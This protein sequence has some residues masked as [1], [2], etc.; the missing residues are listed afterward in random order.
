[1]CI[2]AAKPAG[3]SMPDRETIR[4]MWNGNRDGAGLMYL[5]K[6][7]VRIEKGFMAYKDLANHLDELERRLDLKSIPVVMHLRITTHGGTKP[8]NTHPFPITDSV[9]AL[10]K[11]TI[12]TDVGVAHNGIIPITP[13]KGI[14]D[15]MEYIATQLAPLKRAMPKFYENKHALTLV[16]NAIHSRMAFLSRDGKL[17][18][19]GT[20]IEDNG[21]LYSNTSYQK[22]S[23]YYRGTAYGCY[24]D[25][26]DWDDWYDDYL[27]G[28]STKK[29][30]KKADKKATAAPAAPSADLYDEDECKLLMWLDDDVIIQMA[31]GTLDDGSVG[32]YLLDEYQGV[33]E[34]DWNADLA[35]ELPGAHAVNSELMPVRFDET[36]A[37]AIYT[38]P[39]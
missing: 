30:D 6:G 31:D 12:T 1:M 3:V 28:R 37:E 23:G 13:R 18:T 9:G 8:E 39:F 16:E 36:K 21:M 26:A 22:L 7:Q 20:F 2:I 10:K 33:W 25:Y 38:S 14:S 11:L 32:V 17:T 27:T 29:A 4:T 19:V 15:T 34:Y 5:D 24:S 35:F